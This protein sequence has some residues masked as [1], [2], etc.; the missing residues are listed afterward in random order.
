MHK[1]GKNVIFS[2][3]LTCFTDIKRVQCRTGKP[4]SHRPETY[5]DEDMKYEDNLAKE[6]I[7]QIL[8]DNQ[9]EMQSYVPKVIKDVVATCLGMSRDT[10]NLKSLKNIFC[11]KYRYISSLNNS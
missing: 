5:T 6:R 11:K 8:Q 7:G 4:V 3:I 10:S 2:P 1:F 9:K